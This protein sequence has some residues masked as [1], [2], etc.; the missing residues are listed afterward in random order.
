MSLEA[1]ARKVL[2]SLESKP[3]LFFE[4]LRIVH[5]E[6]HDLLAGPWTPQENAA[7]GDFYYQ[8]FSPQGDT[9]LIV[10]RDE[11]DATLWYWQVVIGDND[12]LEGT[13]PSLQEAR[14]AADTALRDLGWVTS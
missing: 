7:T 4:L 3:D 9:L 14:D 2:E 11:N 12:S 13:L 1:Q 10:S 8:R 5:D 6:G